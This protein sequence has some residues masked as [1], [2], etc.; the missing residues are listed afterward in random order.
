MSQQEESK[1]DSDRS[2]YTVPIR[3]AGELTALIWRGQLFTGKL[4]VAFIKFQVLKTTN[5]QASKK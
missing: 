1:G 4:S 5:F 2:S 3:R